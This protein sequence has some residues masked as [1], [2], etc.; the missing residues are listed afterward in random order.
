MKANFDRMRMSATRAM[1]RLFNVLEDVLENEDISEDNKAQIIEKFNFAAQTVDIMNC[2]Y[3]DSVE[4]DMNDLSHLSIGGRGMKTC[5]YC[6]HVKVQ[7]T[8]DK[9]DVDYEK[10]WVCTIVNTRIAMFFH[11]G[12]SREQEYKNI[13]VFGYEVHPDTPACPNFKQGEI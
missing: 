13:T 11:V 12:G 5:S 2:L 7:L 9:S 4:D 8:D 3:D 1:N 10:P 6:A